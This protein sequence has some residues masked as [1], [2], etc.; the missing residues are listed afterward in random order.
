[1]TT[2]SGPIRKLKS[3]KD[4]KGISLGKYPAIAEYKRSSKLSAYRT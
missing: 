1:M 4:T 2:Y 3:N